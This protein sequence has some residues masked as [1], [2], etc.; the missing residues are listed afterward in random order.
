MAR[1]EMGSPEVIPAGQPAS[2][3]KSFGN[4]IEAI[5]Q[6][7]QFYVIE[8][9]GQEIPDDFLTI[10]GKLSFFNIGFGNGLME[11]MA[12][13]IL[14]AL[15]LPIMADQGVLNFV[16]QYFPLVQHK[17]F[18]ILFNCLPIIISGGICCFLAKYRIGTISKKAVDNFLYGRMFSLAIKGALVFVFLIWISSQITANN[19]W[20]FANFFNFKNDE[21]ARTIYRIIWNMKPHLISTAY[22]MLFIFFIAT[23]IPMISVFTVT[24][25]RG[26]EQRRLDKFWTE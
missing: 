20:A 22:Q 19:A 4:I 1:E 18:L 14:T 6:I 13:A 21:I 12:F 26:W 7:Q 15:I 11:G 16:A 5:S 24:L 23:M 2:T 9:S 10:K 8:K 3:Q 17:P 25:F